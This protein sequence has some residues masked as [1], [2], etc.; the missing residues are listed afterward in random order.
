MTSSRDEREALVTDSAEKLLREQLDA[1]A[2]IEANLG[3]PGSENALKLISQQRDRIRAHLS[4]HPVTG[5]IRD[6]MLKAAGMCDEQV[7]HINEN[8]ENLR[9]FGAWNEQEARCRELA[10]VYVSELAENIR[11]AAP[12]TAASQQINAEEQVKEGRAS[13]DALQPGHP[14][15]SAPNS[16]A[17]GMDEGE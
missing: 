16:A 17:S 1:L 10:A 5:Q 2:A 8:A 7:K 9:K 15:S 4:A 14:V 6:G 12:M 3:W 13:E 11:A